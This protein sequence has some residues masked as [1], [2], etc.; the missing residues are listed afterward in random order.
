MTL[1]KDMDFTRCSRKFEIVFNKILS[2]Y[3]PLGLIIILLGIDICM[4][5]SDTVIKD[6]HIILVFVGILATFVVISNYAQ[7]KDVKY[8]FSKQIK[9]ANDILEKKINDRISDYDN[10]AHGAIYI[11]FGRLNF[12][13]GKMKSNEENINKCTLAFFYYIDALDYIDRTI[14]KR[15]L[16]G[17]FSGI[18]DLHKSGITIKTTSFCKEKAIGLLNKYSA[19][20][21]LINYVKGIKTFER[22]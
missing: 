19:E 12:D 5:I 15:N 6:D 9:G 14:D 16:G 10:V 18:K 2:Q 8:E 22:N 3:I 13:I 11:L 4:H 1:K 20:Q 7:V 21:E 17:V